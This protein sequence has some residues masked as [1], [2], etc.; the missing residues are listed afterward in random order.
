MIKRKH[1]QIGIHFGNSL[2]DKCVNV[3]WRRRV[4]RN[5]VGGSKCLVRRRDGVLARCVS[6]FFGRTLAA[7]TRG[8]RRR[9]TCRHRVGFGELHLSAHRHLLYVL[10]C[11]RRLRLGATLSCAFDLCYKLAA[12]RCSNREVC[13]NMIL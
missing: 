5:R 13:L 10:V 1:S 12:Q 7:R 3:V 9:H 4:W 11:G 6:S 8:G 2:V